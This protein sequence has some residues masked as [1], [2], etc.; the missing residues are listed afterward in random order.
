MRLRCI[1]CGSIYKADPWL[2][3][4]PRCGGLLEVL[5]DSPDPT[6]RR[7]PGVW[8]YSGALPEAESRVSLGE[9]GTPL[10]RLGR[11][12]VYLKF[13]GAN[14]T[15]SFK[16]RGMAVAVSLALDT[17]ARAVLAASTGNT[18]AS[19]AAYAARAGLESIIVLP[20]GRV[21][22]GKLFQAMLHGA[23]IIEVD[24]SF[25]DALKAV[26]SYIRNGG[27]IVYPVNSF[28]QWRL[29]GQK[30]LAFEVIEELG[31][32]P[33]YVFVPV[34]N[35]GNISAIWRGFKEAY[36]AGAASRLPRMIGV[37]ARGA[38]PLATMIERG[39]KE[40]VWFDKPETI[41]TAIRI[42]KP[43]NWPRALMAVEESGGTIIAVGDEEILKAQEELA[44]SEGIGV[45][46]ASAASYAGYKRLRHRIP[47]DSTVVLVATGHAL[48]DPGVEV[49]AKIY[50]AGSPGEAV[51]LIEGLARSSPP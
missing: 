37:Q 45:E 16:D 26:L 11:G 4:C 10:I 31:D 40:P 51:R 30:T 34:G 25:D 15:G 22:R 19:A 48:K 42:G 13:E 47:E 27:R 49:D 41:A 33:D 46:P 50:R 14:P 35:A 2:F 24:G 21:A 6:P 39:S 8:R 32:A 38:S 9:G 36:N 7:G 23:H 18:S 44:R 17:G 43:V 20:R 12:R 28:N 1:S 29:E 3:S 5:H